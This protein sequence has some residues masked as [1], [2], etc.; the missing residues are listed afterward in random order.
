MIS[1]EN[2]MGTLRILFA[3][4]TVALVGCA[5]PPRDCAVPHFKPTIEW[6][7]G[8]GTNLYE[9]RY[10]TALIQSGYVSC[11][12]RWSAGSRKGT[13]PQQS[14]WGGWGIGGGI[15]PYNPWHYQYPK[16]PY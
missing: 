1:E 16:Y 6:A 8:A 10:A 5:A 12:T 4:V 9:D 3:T 13:P 11:V 7:K 15:Q 14:G 2:F